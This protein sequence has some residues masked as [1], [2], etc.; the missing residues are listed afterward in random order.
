MNLPIS[1]MAYT[2]AQIRPSL[3]ILIFLFNSFSNSLTVAQPCHANSPIAPQSDFTSIQWRSTTSNDS[4]VLPVVVHIVWQT[5]EENVSDALIEAQINALND[6]FNAQNID[7]NQVPLSFQQI[8]ANMGISF[9]LAKQ[10]PEGNPSTGITRTKTDVRNIGIATTNGQKTVCYSNLGGIDAWNPKEYIN[11]WVSQM[12]N[13]LAGEANF[14]GD[15]PLS[16]DGIRID[17]DR[18]GTVPFLAGPFSLGRTLTHEMGHYL[19]LQHLWG[20]C[21]ENQDGGICCPNLDPNC[22]CDDGIADTPPQSLTYLNTCNTQFNLTCGDLDIDMSMNF[23]TFSDDACMYM[24]TNGQKQVVLETLQTTRSSLL[25][26]AHA[27][28]EATVSNRHEL[29]NPTNLWKLFPNPA[30]HIV[31]IDLQMLLPRHHAQLSVLSSTGQKVLEEPIRSPAFTINVDG[32]NPGI[33]LVVLQIAGKYS[34]KKL[35]IAETSFN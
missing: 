19:N 15:E 10:D 20:P 28:C 18:F 27:K 13:G 24:F 23:M 32:W 29:A 34:S 16:E 12:G 8:A 14:P 5:P 35:I 21:S 3:A 22:P 2:Y 26:H 1:R 17:V 25:Y 9:C 4:M 30:N 33:Y 31:R 11:I 6:D 7:F